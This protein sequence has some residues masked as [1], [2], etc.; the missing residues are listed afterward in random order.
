[1]PALACWFSDD[2]HCIE[3][4][5]CAAVAAMLAAA[6]LSHLGCAGLLCC[7]RL[8][9]APATGSGA[10]TDAHDAARGLAPHMSVQLERA[11][12]RNRQNGKIYKAV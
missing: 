1:M 2:H 12:V 3:L 7:G 6:L 10:P 9:P 5:H 11:G 4:L 8:T